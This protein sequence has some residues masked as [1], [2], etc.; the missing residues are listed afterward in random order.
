[1][2]VCEA[3]GLAV[4]IPVP[5]ALELAATGNAPG[6][7]VACVLTLSVAPELELVLGETPEEVPDICVEV[8]VD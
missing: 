2:E 5:V 4:S 6:R 8:T 3:E 7:F 1:M